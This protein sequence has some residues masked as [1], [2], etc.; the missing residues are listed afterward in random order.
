MS[1]PIETR[2]LKLLLD[3]LE[4]SQVIF[5]YT[6]GIDF[7]VYLGDGQL[8]DAVERRL[9]IIGEAIQRAKTLDPALAD[10]LPDVRQ[11]V[12][13]RNRIIHSYDEVDHVVVWN[14]VQNELPTL[15]ARLTALLAEA[16]SP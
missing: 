4:S 2:K 7:A 9:G 13:M 12:G 10:Q 6:E 14:V 15:Q 5:R 1:M 8:R 3:A 16:E 11:I